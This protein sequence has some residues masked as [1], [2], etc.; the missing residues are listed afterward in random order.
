MELMLFPQHVVQCHLDKSMVN[1]I[2]DRPSR[3]LKLLIVPLGI[4]DEAWKCNRR[5]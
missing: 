3:L 4:G 1:A 2:A 5:S